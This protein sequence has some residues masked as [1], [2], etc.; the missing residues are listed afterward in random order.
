MTLKPPHAPRVIVAPTRTDSRTPVPIAPLANTVPRV[1][2]IVLSVML[3]ST[4]TLMHRPLARHVLLGSIPFP[5]VR[6]IAPSVKLVDTWAARAP[7]FASTA[8]QGL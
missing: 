4:L 1:R 2:R 7:M 3:E 6:V 8:L 5:P